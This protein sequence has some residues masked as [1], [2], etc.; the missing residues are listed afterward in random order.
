MSSSI[1]IFIDNYYEL[2]SFLLSQNRISDSINLND[3]YRKVLL[4]SCASYYEYLITTILQNFAKHNS[5]DER[6]YYF[7]NNRAIQRQYHTFFRWEQTSSNINHFL[8]LFGSEFKAKISNEIG[9]SKELQEQIRAFLAIGN[10]RNKMAHENFCEYKLEK[11]MDEIISLHN[12]A[13]KF[14]E[15]LQNIFSA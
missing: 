6:I 7:L 11:T 14:V 12:D 4:F 9:K 2:R 5:S 10:E 15:Y 1:Q 13:I 8:G 3:N